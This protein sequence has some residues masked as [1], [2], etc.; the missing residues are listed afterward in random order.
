MAWKKGQSGNPTG[1]PKAYGEL[2]EKLR[3]LTPQAV[4]VLEKNLKSKDAIVAERAA[5]AL[6][7]RAWGK[8][9]QALQP[10]PFVTPGVAVSG[11]NLEN[12]DNLEI[13]RRIAFMFHVAGRKL[14][15]LDK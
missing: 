10:D 14:Q 5:I 13:V 12:A 15:G 3:D 9:A 2:L 4:A 8:P 6:L 1:R 11:M 7:D